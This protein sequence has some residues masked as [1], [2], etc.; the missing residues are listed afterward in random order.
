MFLIPSPSFPSPQVLSVPTFPFGL[1]ASFSPLQSILHVATTTIVLKHNTYHVTALLKT[2]T[3]TQKLYGFLQEK[4][5][6]DYLTGP[7]FL[8]YGSRPSF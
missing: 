5:S 6:A 4:Q 1:C 8:G 7:G 2:K 3:Q